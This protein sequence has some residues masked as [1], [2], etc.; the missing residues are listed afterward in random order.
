MCYNYDPGMNDPSCNRPCPPMSDVPCPGMNMPNMTVAHMIMQDPFFGY[1]AMMSVEDLVNE[2]L[3][4]YNR[5]CMQPQPCPPD[6]CMPQPCPPMP[7]PPDPCM[8]K[9]CPPMPCPPDPCR[10]Q[11]C[12]PQTPCAP[13][14]MPCD[15][16]EK[17]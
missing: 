12:M 14:P 1:Y 10:P 5:K 6:P 3:K 2:A 7:C 9:P 17:E 4:V 13:P 11:P 16:K 8:P 15:T